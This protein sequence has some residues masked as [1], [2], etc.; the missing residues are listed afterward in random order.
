MKEIIIEVPDSFGKTLK[1]EKVNIEIEEEI[2]RC[3]DCKYWQSR[4]FRTIDG[5]E[6]HLCNMADGYNP[7]DWYCADGER[8]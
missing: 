4:L 7:P 1:P 8:P 2:V 6:C 5:K 3:K